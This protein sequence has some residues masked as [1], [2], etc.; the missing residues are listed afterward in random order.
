MS[1]VQNAAENMLAVLQEFVS[2]VDAVG[3]G[4]YLGYEWPD[5]CITYN[6]ARAAIASAIG[7]VEESQMERDRR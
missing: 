3:G 2:D 6:K 5:L 4:P 1:R 7:E